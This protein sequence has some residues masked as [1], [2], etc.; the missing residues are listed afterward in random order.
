MPVFRCPRALARE[1]M[2]ILPLFTDWKVSNR[3]MWPNGQPRLKQ[4]VKL[5]QAFD[6]LSELLS[7]YQH[8]DME[9][10]VKDAR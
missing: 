3:V 9:E 8:E 5:A 4:P 10:R 6:L 2:Y 7:R 1:V